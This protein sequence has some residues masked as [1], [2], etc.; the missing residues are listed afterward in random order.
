MCVLS[1]MSKQTILLDK[2]KSDF[3]IAPQ[4]KSLLATLLETMVTIIAILFGI[5]QN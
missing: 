4:I 1:L 3:F 2:P 5:A